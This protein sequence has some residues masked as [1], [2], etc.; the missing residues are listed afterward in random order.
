MKYTII[1]LIAVAL[2]GC[3]PVSKPYQTEE[4]E[5]LAP[6][7]DP[8]VISTETE[9][10]R[11]IPGMVYIPKGIFWMGCDQDHN[12]GLTCLPDELP[13]HEVTL[14]GY[15]M[16]QFEV[17]N[18][19]YA[20]CVEAGACELPTEPASNTLTSYYDNSAYKDYPV[21]FVSWH[22]A[23]AYCEWAGKR[24]PTEAEWEKA[25]RG[26]TINGFP[27]GDN[28]PGCDLANFYDKE[29]SSYCVRDTSRV[30]DYSEGASPFGVMNMAGNVWEW[31][32]DWYADSYYSTSPFE[33]PAGP[34]SGMYKVLRGGGFKSN[35]VQLRSAN[36]SYDPD[37]NNSEDVGFRC[38]ISLENP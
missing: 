23:K 30:D 2:I 19:E 21:I 38:A 13:L 7:T 4:V 29:S 20:R 36:R 10:A 11:P 12:G 33:D 5:T 27:W 26:S 15:Y 34:D 14:E 22:D 17:T 24:L 8:T 9:R 32:N 1:A 16:D 35:V 18:R 31:V 28:Q 25:A 3:T 37:F 6:G